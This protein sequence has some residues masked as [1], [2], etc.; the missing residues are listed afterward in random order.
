MT[1][2]SFPVCQPLRLTSGVTQA[3]QNPIVYTEIGSGIEY[4]AI[5]DPASQAELVIIRLDPVKIKLRVISDDSSLYDK[6]KAEQP[7]VIIN[8]GYFKREGE[9]VVPEGLVISDG[10][11]AS[12]ISTNPKFSGI[13]S[14]VSGAPKISWANQPVGAGVEQALQAGPLVVE[15]GGKAGIKS[16]AHDYHKSPRAV[17]ATD[18]NDKLYF[19]VSSSIG[20]FDLQSALL[21]RIAGIKS[22][23]NLD[24]GNSAGIIINTAQLKCG[25]FP[26]ERITPTAIGV[27]PVIK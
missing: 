6:S 5:S 15:P 4:A 27:F 18:S 2:V 25:K 7:L 11:Q 23:L 8:G 12:P 21:R 16:R 19:I 3:A 24:G 26:G 9:S 17:I 10:D 1:T 13:F 22:A 20:L 14:L